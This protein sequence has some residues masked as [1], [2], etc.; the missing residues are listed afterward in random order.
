[1]ASPGVYRII[2]FLRYI[3]IEKW[4]VS[5]LTTLP[6][7][8]PFS[9]DKSL[10]KLL[11]VEFRIFRTKILGSLL[12]ESHLAKKMI[13]AKSTQD[14]SAANAGATG[15]LSKISSLFFIPDHLIRWRPYA[16]NAAR[17]IDAQKNIDIIYSTSPFAS[18]HLIGLKLKRMFNC[19]WV[20]ELRDHWSANPFI[21]YPTSYHKSRN[22]KLESEV[23]RRSD[24]VITVS[25]EM[26]EELIELHPEVKKS[27]FITVTNGFEPNDT[28]V[29][30]DKKSS[31]KIIISHTGSFYG[32]RNP[33]SFLKALKE[34]LI[35]E[36]SFKKKVEI[37]FAGSIEPGFL[38]EIQ[39][40]KL[41]EN[42]KMLGQMTRDESIEL[43]QSS[44]I[45]LLIPGPGRGTLSGKT[46]EYLKARKPVLLLVEDEQ[47]S[48]V[49]VLKRAGLSISTDIN[50]KNE[51]KKKLHEI[52]NKL[53]NKEMDLK[54]DEEYI[55]SFRRDAIINKFEIEL[56]N[57]VKEQK[58][59]G[60]Q[61]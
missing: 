1:M 18:D 48:T 57:L 24:L 17:K 61:P 58:R 44:D 10:C 13:M 11:P 40:I 23:L 52:V 14:T 51:I 28:Q 60:L 6:D 5:L 30:Q 26:K 56:L 25:D 33:L 41:G 43:Q 20:V 21:K 36:P 49:K 53:L 27:K 19:P 46:F 35:E 16:V 54:P 55:N 38:R 39:N 32:A 7:Y 12:M 37:V 59:Y 50:N 3:D 45:L 4:D 31:D 22:Y 9:V 15:I 42:L 2:G 29:T 8:H 34:L 47:S